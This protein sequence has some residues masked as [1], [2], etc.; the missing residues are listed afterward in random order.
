MARRPN[1]S[2]QTRLLLLAMLDA[3]SN[4]R[5]GYELSRE[6]GLKSGTLYPILMRL[7]DRGLLESKWQEP[8]QAGRPPRHAYRLTPDGLAFART[9]APSRVPP[10]R[11]RRIAGAAA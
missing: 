3:P 9:L 5:H 10:M 1:I 6:T 8:E 7:S 11:R 4:W 2:R